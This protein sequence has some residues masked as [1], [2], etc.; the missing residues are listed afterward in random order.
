M[1]VPSVSGRPFSSLAASTGTS[2]TAPAASTGT[3]SSTSLVGK[4]GTVTAEDSRDTFLKLLVA[5]LEHQD[6]LKPMENADFTAQLAQFSM[7]E[8][9]EAMNKNLRSMV[10]AQQGLNGLEAKMQA[11]SPVGKEVA[12]KGDTTQVHDGHAT[13]LA[14]NLAAPSAHVSIEILNGAGQPVQVFEETNKAAGQYAV[15]LYGKDKRAKKLPDGV[16]AVRVTA[17]DGAGQPV[18]VE[19]FIQGRVNGV[20]YGTDQPYFL[21]NKNRVAFSDIVSIQH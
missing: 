9:L 19:T 11:T 3:A 17:K 13:K 7:L 4:I 16:Y 2:S 18:A 12:I 10:D 6:P 20:E 1:A 14:Y 8:Q 15:P 21:M 5:Q